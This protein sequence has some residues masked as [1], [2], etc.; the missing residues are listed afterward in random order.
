[1]AFPILAFDW[2]LADDTCADK[3]EVCVI[4]NTYIVSV[5]RILAGLSIHPLQ[6]LPWVSSQSVPLP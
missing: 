6:H 5:G 3:K 1:M 2:R 4:L